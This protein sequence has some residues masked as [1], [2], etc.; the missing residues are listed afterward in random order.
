MLLSVNKK[1]LSILSSAFSFSNLVT[2]FLNTDILSF[3]DVK[4]VIMVTPFK[5][6]RPNKT[7]RVTIIAQVSLNGDMLLIGSDGKLY[8]Q[9]GNEYSDIKFAISMVDINRLNALCND[10]NYNIASNYDPKEKDE[11]FNKCKKNFAVYVFGFNSKNKEFNT[12]KLA[13]LIYSAEI[14]TWG[15]NS[16]KLRICSERIH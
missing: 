7:R 15:G 1:Q 5:L 9:D 8:L 16:I 12:A 10:I 2:S 13:N 3:I 11:L 4:D 14:K 6:S